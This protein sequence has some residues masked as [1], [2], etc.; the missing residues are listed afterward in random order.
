VATTNEGVTGASADAIELLTADHRE[1]A[2]LFRHLEAA[3][4]GSKVPKETADK[5]VREL[6]VHAVV[7]EMILYP[8][9]RE[10]VGEDEVGHAI[11]EH[12]EIKELLARVDG[13][14]VDD[15]EV[16][17][18]FLRVKLAVEE[19]VQEEESELFPALRRAF[20][21]ERLQQMGRAIEMAK[22]VAPTHPHP[23]APSTPPGNIVVGL[24]SAV[25][26]RVR[27]VA[28]D[29]MRR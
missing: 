14:P 2:Q 25:I 10:A 8:A 21:Q 28:R 16:Q 29:A 13:K 4:P 20:D 11:E 5:I 17:S 27:D 7:E 26:D 18:T 22:A 24:A 15:S 6:S 3:E 12:Q 23:N 1:V 19:H 9:A